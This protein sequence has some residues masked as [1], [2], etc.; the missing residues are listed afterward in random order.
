MTL[1]T[2]PLP[3]YF[4]I[5]QDLVTL[6][7]SGELKP[8]DQMPTEE[9]LC[10]KYAVSRGT[11]RQAIQQLDSEG[12]IRRER[13][14]GT[15]V[16]A[17]QNQS[18]LFSLEPFA[19]ALIRQGRVPSTKLLTAVTQPATPELAEKL[20]LPKN[21]PVIQISRLRL[22]DGQ[23]VAHETRYLAEYLCPNLLSENLE[24]DAIHDL[25]VNKYQIPLV[26]MTHTVEAGVLDA[27]H[28][29][30]FA[31][32]SKHDLTGPKT[33]TAAFFIDRLT[34]TERVNTQ[35]PAVWFKAIYLDHRLDLGANLRPSL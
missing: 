24:D 16:S 20:Q 14:N 1:K 32:N 11:V 9:A 15:F 3:K 21:E 34:Y 23:P 6:I 12:L 7:E 5:A 18:T 27:Q 35:V 4:Q 33:G 30:L 29:E 8:N 25:L 31:I 13:G 10:E 2:P 17:K 22:A 19:Q 28:L 26:K